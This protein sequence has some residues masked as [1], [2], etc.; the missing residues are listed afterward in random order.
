[1]NN[2]EVIIKSSESDRYIKLYDNQ[3]DYFTVLV[4]SKSCTGSL[5]VYKYLK[6]NDLIALFKE[7]SS[8]ANGWKG[9]YSWSSLEEEF[10]IELKC[11][12]LGHIII[13]TILTNKNTGGKDSWYLE[14]IIST[15]LGMLPGISNDI[16]SFFKAII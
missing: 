15:E 2:H 3:K 6:C 4:S 14:S 13:K 9:E 16:E 1:M 5:K 7:V 8:H 12:N 10:S 11:D